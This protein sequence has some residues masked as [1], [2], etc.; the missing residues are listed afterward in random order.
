VK[1]LLEYSPKGG[2]YR[3]HLGAHVYTVTLNSAGKAEAVYRVK[4]DKA[5]ARALKFV[6]APGRSGGNGAVPLAI[7][8]AR[9]QGL[10]AA[11]RRA[12]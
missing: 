1:N 3:V 9:V 10:L 7:H 6:W 12:G 8:T 5:G 2:E 11:R 4:K